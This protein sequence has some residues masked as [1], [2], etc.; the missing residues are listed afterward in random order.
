MFSVLPTRPGRPY[1]ERF[2]HQVTIQTSYDI[3]PG[4]VV[5]VWTFAPDGELR[6][7]ADSYQGYDEHLAV[8]A[9]T[10]WIAGDGVARR[11]L[12]P[13]DVVECPSGSRRVI[14]T[15]ETLCLLAVSWDVERDED[16]RCPAQ[17]QQLRVVNDAIAGGRTQPPGAGATGT[18]RGGTPYG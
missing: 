18:A 14:G 10:G 4:I 17:R 3:P 11:P 12:Q 2:A 6:H 1:P 7:G 13:G 16:D 8:L 5:G 15:D 9:G